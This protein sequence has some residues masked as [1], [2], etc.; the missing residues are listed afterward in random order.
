M[1]II[2]LIHPTTIDIRMHIQN[3]PELLNG[4]CHPNVNQLVVTKCCLRFRANPVILCSCLEGDR[5][6]LDPT[7]P[8]RFEENL[9]IFPSLRLGSKCWGRFANL[10]K[11]L[12]T[13]LL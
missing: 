13:I 12:H 1:L 3:I 5:V 4:K 7:G 10:Q 6:F 9:I 8:V 11:L 2:P